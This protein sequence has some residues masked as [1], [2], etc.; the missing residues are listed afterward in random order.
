VWLNKPRQTLHG[1]GIMSDNK[2]EFVPIHRFVTMELPNRQRY[3]VRVNFAIMILYAVA[4]V[5]KEFGIRHPEELSLMRSPND[6][7]NFSKFTGW[8]KRRKVC[9]FVGWC[10]CMF[11]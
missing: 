9:L 6:K 4:E 5:C 3:Q 2:L 8:S 10:V 11:V 1:Y 7:E